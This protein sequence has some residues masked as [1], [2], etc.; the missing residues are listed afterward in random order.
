MDSDEE[1]AYNLDEVSSDVEVQLGGDEAELHDE[2][3]DTP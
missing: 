1:D 2:D 3:D